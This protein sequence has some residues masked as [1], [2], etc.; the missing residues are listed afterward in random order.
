VIELTD[1]RECANRI[2]C[3]GAVAETHRLLPDVKGASQA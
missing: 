1:N 3:A 2:P